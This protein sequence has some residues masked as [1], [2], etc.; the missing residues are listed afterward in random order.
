[1]VGRRASLFGIYAAVQLRVDWLLRGE[2]W[3][4]G[5]E[6]LFVWA[7]ANRGCSPVGSEGLPVFVDQGWGLRR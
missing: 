7:M 2:R 5:G 6:K 1:M 3:G 4:M